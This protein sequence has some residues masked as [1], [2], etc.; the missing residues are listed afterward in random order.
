MVAARLRAAS[1]DRRARGPGASPLHPPPRIGGIWVLL[2]G[3]AW[4]GQGACSYLHSL[5]LE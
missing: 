4:R 5:D 1:A 2:G 3:V